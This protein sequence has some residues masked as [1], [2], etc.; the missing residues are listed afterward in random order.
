ME[1]GYERDAPP[2]THLQDALPLRE[3]EGPNHGGHLESLLKQVAATYV[4]EGPVLLIQAS[5]EDP[6]RPADAPDSAREVH[7]PSFEARPLVGY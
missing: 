3:P 1:Q 2:A 5:P 4:G 7:R 6:R